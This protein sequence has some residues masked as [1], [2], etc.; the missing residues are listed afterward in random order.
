MEKLTYSAIGVCILAVSLSLL[1]LKNSFYLGSLEIHYYGITMMSAF[2]ACA[3]LGYTLFKRKGI[4]GDI[5]FDAMLAIIPCAIV[6][7]RIW[8]VILD[9]DEFKT[10]S[11]KFDFVA[12]LKIWNGGL[13][14]HGGVLGGALGLLI[15]SKVKKVSLGKLCDCGATALPLGQAIGRWGNFFN[16]EVYGKPTTVKWFPYSVYIEATGQY[17]L[18]LFFY[19]MVL[20]LILFA[21][22]MVFFYNYK[23]RRNL[24]STS[25]YLIGYGVIRACLEPLR[26][27]EYQMGYF[28]I[29]ASVITSIVCLIAGLVLFG[30]QLY[31]DI[32]EKNYWWKDMFKKAEKN[33]EENK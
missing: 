26:M 23:G 5:I 11:G 27:A 2:V 33:A 29:P 30:I 9:L 18:A 15:V 13:A 24:Y 25:F 10:A 20:N 31:R 32:S 7:A 21:L 22:L 3:I 4:D 6:C 16:Q 17:H 8:Y 1:L 19:E 28:G 12:T 14:I